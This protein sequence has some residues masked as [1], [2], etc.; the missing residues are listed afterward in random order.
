MKPIPDS[1]LTLAREAAGL[2]LTDA[3]R[4]VGIQPD[5]LRRIERR[6]QA[7][8][9]LAQKL[10]RRYRCSAM[11]FA[12]KLVA[13]SSQ[14][15][16]GEVAKTKIRRRFLGAGSQRQVSPLKIPAAQEGF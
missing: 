14:P 16:K 4:S 3:A 9:V 15:M 2:T 11:V 12:K 5:Y 6:G 10:S 8:Y 7:P 1:P 13:G